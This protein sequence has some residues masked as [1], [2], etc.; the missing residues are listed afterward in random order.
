MWYSDVTL[1]LFVLSHLF[2][3]SYCDIPVLQMFRSNKYNLKRPNEVKPYYWHDYEISSSEEDYSYFEYDDIDDKIFQYANIQTR[4][5]FLQF[6]MPKLYDSSKGLCPNNRTCARKCC[7]HFL[8]FNQ[9]TNRCTRLRTQDKF[10][11]PVWQGY[12]LMKGINAGDELYFLYGYVNCGSEEPVI[13][14]TGV[15]LQ[16]DG[17]IMVETTSAM[18]PELV[19]KVNQYCL[20]LFITEDNE[21]Q[22]NALVCHLRTRREG[23]HFYIIITCLVISCIFMVLNVIV[24]GLL[25]ELRPRHKLLIIAYLISFLLCA[26]VKFVEIIFILREKANRNMCL[27]FTFLYYFFFLL[28]FFWRNI[29]CYDMWWTISSNRPMSGHGFQ[30]RIRLFLYFVYGIG[31]PASLTVLLASLEFSE[32]KK[33][34]ELMPNIQNEGCNALRGYSK[35]IY[36]YGPVCFLLVINLIIFG[37]TIRKIHK[38]K[39]QTSVVLQAEDSNTHVN[40]EEQWVHIYVKIFVVMLLA[41]MNFTLDFMS[42]LFPYYELFSYYSDLHYLT[43]PFILYL[44]FKCQGHSWR[45]L[46]KR[47]ILKWPTSENTVSTTV[48]SQESSQK[49]DDCRNNS[50]VGSQTNS[51]APM[52]NI[53]IIKC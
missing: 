14:N 53:E 22:L 49:V 48:R 5:P 4:H 18:G 39:K 1:S 50:E 20:D 34:N 51:R 28:S 25:P 16:S 33:D 8:G 21:I 32:F 36:Q 7:S 23:R 47:Y 40:K 45:N 12:K 17:T 9:T 2:I 30:S 19:F 27:Y 35:A 15:R 43:F 41:E 6:F 46:I 13:P 26:I 37:L 44:N 29:M 31:M 42:K 11:P 3:T 52:S 24:Y 10:N 38:I